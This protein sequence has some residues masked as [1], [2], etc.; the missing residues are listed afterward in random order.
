M[1]ANNNGIE[2]KLLDSPVNNQIMKLLRIS[3]SKGLSAFWS[4]SNIIMRF[5]I[6]FVHVVFLIEI[7]SHKSVSQLVLG[8]KNNSWIFAFQCMSVIRCALFDF[9]FHCSDFNF[10]F[11]WFLFAAISFGLF[12]SQGDTFNAIVWRHSNVHIR[13]Y[14]TNTKVY[15]KQ[16]R[17]IMKKK[18][19]SWNELS[20]QYAKRAYKDWRPT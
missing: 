9:R 3:L 8:C 4:L 12:P 6:H 17:E 18:T 7:A 13:E 14:H 19:H 15:K 5:V 16:P 20:H 11:G 2:C 10:R 1:I